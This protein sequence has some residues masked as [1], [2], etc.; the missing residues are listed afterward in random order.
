MIEFSPQVIL[1]EIDNEMVLLD[2]KSG[3]YF[4]LNPTATR[5][6]QELQKNKD[7]AAVASLLAQEYKVE[8][9]RIRQ[10]LDRL[11]QQLHDKGLVSLKP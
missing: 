6:V 5:M 8:V 7:P 2:S 10:D 1:S 9:Q 11:L 3:K 4:G